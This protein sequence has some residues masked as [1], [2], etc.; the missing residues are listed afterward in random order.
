MARNDK[1]MLQ[2]A[3]AAANLYGVISTAEF[4]EI[5]SDYFPDDAL[6]ALD[7]EDVLDL[8]AVE[9]SAGYALWS[10]HVVSL[11]L[12]GDDVQCKHILLATLGKPRYIP[13]PEEMLR[14]INPKY[15]ERTPSAETLLNYLR[16]TCRIEGAEA[17]EITA[18]MLELLT[19]EVPNVIADAAGV[20]TKHGKTFPNQDAATRFIN[21]YVQAAND[22]RLWVNRGHSPAE[23]A[24]LKPIE[25][26]EM[27]YEKA[28]IN[29]PIDTEVAKVGRND[30][31]PCG[32]GLKYK[33]CHGR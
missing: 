9:G 21:I 28:S 12:R 25:N 4:A 15:F 33:R 7:A 2:Y 16:D 32:S 19:G 30:P 10:S 14:Y 26:S 13:E 24:A 22:K 5:Y 1:R 31:C 20:L 23:L 8:L 6:D 3:A 17:I 18:E 11:R 27:R 29:L